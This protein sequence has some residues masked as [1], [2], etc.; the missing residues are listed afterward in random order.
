ME[1]Q[2]VINFSEF[3]SLTG[4]EQRWAYGYLRGQEEPGERRA[5]HQGTLIHLGLDRWNRGMGA[6]LPGEWTDDIN[7]GGKP[8]EERTLRL[9]DFDPEVVDNALWLLG[10]YR[11]HYGAGP[12]SSWLMID[13]ERWLSTALDELKLLVGRTDGVLEIEGDDE[14]PDGL[15]LLERKSYGGKGRLD[16]VHVDPQLVIYSMLVEAEYGRKLTGVV[17]DGIYT[18]HWKPAKPTQGAV[19]EERDAV[20]PAWRV[21]LTPTEQ[22]E[23]ARAEVAAHPGVDRP[24]AESFERRYVDISDEMREVGKNYLYAAIRRRQ[25]LKND[26]AQALPNIGQLCRSC[27]FRPQCWSNLR[28][29]E[30]PEY[31]N[32]IEV[33]DATEEPV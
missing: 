18:Y 26:P 5:L 19:M 30:P 16:Y 31:D 11:D 8:G 13:S 17:F 28:G 3:W 2:E 21:H 7:T 32:E 25:V 29:G 14:I 12:P 20:N 1:T 15:W 6:N 24:A 4:C 10:R 23:W 9:A 33:F 22:R 27:G